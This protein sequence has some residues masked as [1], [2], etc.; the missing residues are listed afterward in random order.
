[1]K[2]FAFIIV[3]I[4]AATSVQTQP[5]KFSNQG[6]P[7]NRRLRRPAERARTSQRD[8]GPPGFPHPIPQDS[9]VDVVP[10][11]K[12][13]FNPRGTKRQDTFKR[14]RPR[15]FSGRQKQT[16]G[17][18]SDSPRD[19]TQTESSRKTSQQDRSF[20][21]QFD[22]SPKRPSGAQQGNKMGPGPE[23]FDRPTR[24]PAGSRQGSRSP[25]GAP[26]LDIY[27]KRDNQLD[28]GGNMGFSLDTQFEGPAQLI[29]KLS[30]PSFDTSHEFPFDPPRPSSTGKLDQRP[31]SPSGDRKSQAGS[32]RQGQ[33]PSRQ[34]KFEKNDPISRQGQKVKSRQGQFEPSKPGR[35]HKTRQGQGQINAAGKRGADVSRD[36]QPKGKL[37]DRQ[38]NRSPFGYSPDFGSLPSSMQPGTMSQGQMEVMDQTQLTAG[39][40]GDFLV[41]GEIQI[42]TALLKAAGLLGGKDT[43]GQKSTGLPPQGS[44][45]TP[46]QSSKDVS[47][48]G[49]FGPL[50]QGNVDLTGQGGFDPSVGPD[51]YPQQGEFGP[52]TRPVD[53]PQQG[54]F[55]PSVQPDG[56]PQQG[57]FDPSVQPNG[58]PKQGGFAPSVR[59]DSGQQQGGFDS[60]VRYDGG[61]QQGGFDP[62]IRPD[63]GPQQ[64]GFDPS[65]RR[66]GGPQGGYDP[67]QQPDS[68]TQQGGFDPPVRING[69]PQQ[70][71][72]PSVRPNGGPQQDFFPSVQPDSGPQR[73]G[74]DPSFRPD[75]G[76]Q[77][78]GFE[79]LVRPDGGPQQ[80]L[81]PSG[82]A[83][84]EKFDPSGQVNFADFRPERFGPSREPAFGQTPTEVPQQGQADA[85]VSSSE[86][87][88][89]GQSVAD[90]LSALLGKLK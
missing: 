48:Q 87:E 15:P 37:F 68:G 30:P 89:Q 79:P 8:K 12:G 42:P 21:K 39:G 3:L 20:P 46:G 18:I 13:P 23:Q 16:F 77:Q 4:V 6:R 84:S 73:R 54:G 5:R 61:P 28:V 52:S 82:Q 25:F 49:D 78:E 51:S 67:S 76:P 43:S 70:G 72:D 24:K 11:E 65:V 81:N 47:Q 9:Q 33:E 62:S 44:E 56:G 26:S 17:S 19:G 57:G 32:S 36:I 1:M 14:P 50:S 64:G 60:S 41:E 38:N 35:F 85:N 71:F 80:G 53:S 45:N 40:Q 22:S 10:L 75:S 7:W 58:G 88:G 27:T 74:F 2:W 29:D 66:D 83:Q 31:F 86:T 90:R 34:G 69:G 63:S 59:L 55:D